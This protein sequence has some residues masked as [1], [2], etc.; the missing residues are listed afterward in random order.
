MI[1]GAEVVDDYTV[2]LAQRPRLCLS[3]RIAVGQSGNLGIRDE[4][5][6]ANVL[7]THGSRANDGEPQ[8]RGGCCIHDD[9]AEK[10]GLWL[11]S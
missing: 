2:R 3:P 4:L 8:H 5:Q 1:E 11:G 6:I 9:C 7:Q 10:I